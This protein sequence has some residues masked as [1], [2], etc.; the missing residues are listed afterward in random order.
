MIQVK[1]RGFRIEIGEIESAV[2]A[3]VDSVAS[4]GGGCPCTRI[5]TPVI[6][7]W[8]RM[9]LLRPAAGP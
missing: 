2:L 6:S 9:S 4:D 5:L 1:I 7:G 8:W 3:D